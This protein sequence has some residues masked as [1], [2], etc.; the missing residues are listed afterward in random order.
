[1]TP[2]LLVAGSL[3]LF[4]LG[5]SGRR[6]AYHLV[7]TSTGPTERAH[8]ARVLRRGSLSCHAVA[9]LFVIAAIAAMRP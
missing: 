5:C 1:M 8:R 6:N 3:V 9:V 4:L 2:V 7:P